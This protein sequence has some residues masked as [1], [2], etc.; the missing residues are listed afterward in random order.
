MCLRIKV[1]ELRRPMGFCN[2]YF[3]VDDAVN[4]VAQA[5]DLVDFFD[6]A[7][8][9]VERIAVGARVQRGLKQDVIVRG[10]APRRAR[11]GSRI[12]VG[13]TLQRRRGG[14]HRI[15]VPVRVPRS[16]KP[17]KVHRLTI[18][19]GG[20]GFSEEALIDELIEIIDEQLGG[21][22][23]TSEPTTV[24]QLARRIHSLRRVPG[25]YARFDR[26]PARLVRR[27]HGVS[28]E[29]RVRLRVRVTPR[30]RR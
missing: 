17:G 1:R 24:R 16:L 10:R 7:P 29:G 25:I 26:R 9:H 3:S 19:G 6:L 22:G 12:R 20:G 5:G 18:R 11:K 4:D 23:G 8:L 13:L 28:F 21:G 30:V 2:L 14:R 15:S 27:S